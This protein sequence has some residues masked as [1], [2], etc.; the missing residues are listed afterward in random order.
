MAL[1]KERSVTPPPVR[2]APRSCERCAAALE[3]EDLRCP[4]CGLTAPLVVALAPAK[5]VAAVV[6]CSTCSACVAYSAEARAPRCSFCGCEAKVDLPEDPVDQASA[7][8]PFRV[9]PAHAREALLRYWRGLGWFRPGDLAR[10]AKVEALQPIWWPAWVINATADV[11][12]TADSDAGAEKADWAPHAGQTRLVLRNCVI[13]ASRGLSREE[14]S[15]L[16]SRYDLGEALGDVPREPTG[17]QVEQ[18]DLRRS[19]ARAQILESVQEQAE[20]SVAETQ[21]PGSRR[22]NVHVAVMLSGLETTRYALP[23]Y[24]LAYRYRQ[25]L[26]R[27]V[28]HG[29][30]VSQVIARAPYSW[31]RIA[32]AVAAGLLGIGLLAAV[33]AHFLGG[34]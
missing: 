26:F 31:A 2:P 19:G 12:W 23:A 25:R 34:R 7:F 11:S 16:T 21:V 32:L 3:P 22:R 6:R 18:F 5:P 14:C 1:P 15:A 9:A 4:L 33:A 20:R 24:V 30:E 28:V 17:S 8:L 13:P 10:V 29:Q 27:A